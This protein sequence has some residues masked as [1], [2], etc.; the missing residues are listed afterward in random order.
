MQFAHQ[1]ILQYRRA[2]NSGAICHL[3]QPSRHRNVF[4]DRSSIRLFTVFQRVDINEG[5]GSILIMG[6]RSRRTRLRD[7]LVVILERAN[8]RRQ[9]V[10][11]IVQ[12]FRKIAPCSYASVHIRH[13]CRIAASPLQ[14]LENGWVN[15]FHGLS[16]FYGGTG[17]NGCAVRSSTVQAGYLRL[18]PASF[19]I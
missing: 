4:A 18:I 13:A 10:A 7:G 14:R 11:Y 19:R 17:S 6:N 1:R 8:T 2:V 15:S 3:A 5:N 16:S 9:R 12:R